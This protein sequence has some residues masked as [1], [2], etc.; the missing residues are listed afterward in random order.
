MGNKRTNA[1]SLVSQQVDDKSV[2]HGADAGLFVQVVDEALGDGLSGGVAVSVDDSLGTVSSFAGQV[3]FSVVAVKGGTPLGEFFDQGRSG[4]QSVANVA[5]TFKFT[6]IPLSLP[7]WLLC[8]RN[9][10]GDGTV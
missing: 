8:P 9:A 1:S 10:Y 5:T 6:S 4:S 3:E 7:L 2:F